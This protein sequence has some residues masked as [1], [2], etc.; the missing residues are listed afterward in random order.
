[1]VRALCRHA[2][3]QG[4]Q[5]QYR[6]QLDNHASIAFA[7]PAGLTLFW[8]WETVSDDSTDSADD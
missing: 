6:C 1:M 4:Y 7:K 8:T 2:A 3:E 5:P